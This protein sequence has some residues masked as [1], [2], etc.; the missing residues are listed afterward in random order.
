MPQAYTEQETRDL[1]M[2]HVR[3]MIDYWDK[4]PEHSRRSALEGLAFSILVALDG[5]SSDLPAFRV[6]PAPHPDDEQYHREQGDNWYDP[7]VDI[8]GPLHESLCINGSTGC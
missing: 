7:E 1:F 2:E 3:S 5:E 8:S 4:C 6:M